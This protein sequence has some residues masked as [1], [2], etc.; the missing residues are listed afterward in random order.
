[1]LIRNK[2]KFMLGFGMMIAFFAVLFLM[3]MP[4]FGGTNA[5][6]A[7]DGLF[8]S[9]SKASTDYFDEAREELAAATLPPMDKSL[10]MEPA[11]G[12][13]AM[14]QLN[15]VGI[16]ASYADGKLTFKGEL[17]TLLTTWIEDAWKMYEND[18][19]AIQDKYGMDHKRALYN[20]YQLGDALSKSY[21]L[22]G[23]FDTAK[24]VDSIKAKT[25]EVGYNFYGV[26]PTPASERI[27]I[28][29][30]A[31][32]FYVFY[33]MWWGY[34]IFYLCEGVGL[35]MTKTSKKEG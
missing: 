19:Q 11:I 21:N 13:G 22:A 8:N 18:G 6:H 33:T 24:M 23:E 17:K 15:I 34:S 31:M 2:K 32:V 26:E 16:E 35:L 30:F 1:M 27:G 12:E 29:L 5:F 28:M 10:E 7:A 9:I 14:N 20:W 3:F 4:I 25:V